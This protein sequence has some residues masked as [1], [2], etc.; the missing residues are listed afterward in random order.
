NRNHIQID[1]NAANL[2]ESEFQENLY[3]Q[4]KEVDKL[5]NYAGEGSTIIY[6]IAAEV[7][8]PSKT[9][10]AFQFVDAVLH[11]KLS[12]AVKIFNELEKMTEESISLIALLALHSSIIYQV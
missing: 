3:M 10:N 6:E 1:K 4:E 7:I 5:V 2:L 12:Q 11:K 9:F 8:S